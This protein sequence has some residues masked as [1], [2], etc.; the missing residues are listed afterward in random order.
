MIFSFNYLFTADKNYYIS[1]YWMVKA[2]CAVNMVCTKCILT[3][4][5]LN[6]LLPAGL[7]QAAAVQAQGNPGR[8]SW[9]STPLSTHSHTPCIEQHYSNTSLQRKGFWISSLFTLL[10]VD[11]ISLLFNSISPF[12]FYLRSISMYT[13]M[14]VQ[15][16]SCTVYNL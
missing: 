12:F 6:C 1:F 3:S 10:R 8:S 5:G 9:H 4:V 13:D 2:P 11:F 14:V 16:I 7:V 15:R